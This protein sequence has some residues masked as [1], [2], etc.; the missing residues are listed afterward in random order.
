M[1]RRRKHRGS[2]SIV[3]LQIIIRAGVF[4]AAITGVN[5]PVNIHHKN[6]CDQLEGKL[7]KG[8]RAVLFPLEVGGPLFF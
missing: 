6:C 2:G 5:Q 8:G 4:K 1:H 7:V 3:I